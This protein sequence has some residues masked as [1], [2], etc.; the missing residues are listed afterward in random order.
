[1]V[2]T[3]DPCSGCFFLDKS[4]TLA[5]VRDGSLG[6]EPGSISAKEFPD[7]FRAL[8]ISGDQTTSSVSA[9]YAWSILDLH[10]WL[11]DL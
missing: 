2:Q 4:H 9:G 7:Y 10:N 3:L 5:N 11:H 1:M 8:G 6:Y